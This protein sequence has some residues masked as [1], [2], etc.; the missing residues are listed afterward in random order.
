MK[1]AFLCPYCAQEISWTVNAENQAPA[2][3]HCRRTI[4]LTH[5]P[6]LIKTAQIDRCS[7][8]Q[9]DRFYVQ[10]DFNRILGVVIIGLGLAISY[11]LFGFNMA[12]LILG[13]T[14]CVVI[15][16]VLHRILPEVTVCYR[17]HSIY[18]HFVRNPAHKPFDLHIAEEYEPK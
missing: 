13:L 12:A 7:I 6:S 9:G 18:R 16:V 10:K 11:F 14:V 4:R 17:C 3:P 5:A 2:C 8:C 1:I 15:D